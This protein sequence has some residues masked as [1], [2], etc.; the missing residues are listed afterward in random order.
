MEKI[1]FVTSN[2]GKVK[3][4]QKYFE[5]I[6][7]IYYKYDLIEPR[8][9]SLE[10][11]ARYKVIQAYEQVKSNCIALD[12]GFFIESLNNWPETFV[13]FNLQK[14]GLEGILKILLK[15]ENRNAYFK[16]CLA[17]FDGREVKYFYGLSKGTIAQN[18]SMVNNPN[19]WSSLW[20]IFIP[21]NH[22]KTMVDMSDEERNNRIDGHTSSFKEFNAWVKQKKYNI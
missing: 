6:E 14:L 22:N 7:L 18:I 16:E 11:I 1:V 13:N 8:S 12:S 3:S 17:Y 19:Q 5:D 9:E 4:A 21:I 10:E 20:Q 2:E 15:V